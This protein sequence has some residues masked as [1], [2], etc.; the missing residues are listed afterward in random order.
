MR[1]DAALEQRLRAAERRVAELER[2]IG[3]TYHSPP[4]L[5]LT[6]YTGRLLGLLVVNDALTVEQLHVALYDERK[7]TPATLYNVH[8]FVKKLR[9]RLSPHG[10]AIG[11]T[12]GCGFW[13]SD[14]DKARIRSMSGWSAPAS[15]KGAPDIQP[16]ITA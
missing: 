7:V 10:I 6:P 8:C 12:T 1:L 4:Q 14:A 2:L 9:R 11:H 5:R 16:G 13:L 15:R 3:L